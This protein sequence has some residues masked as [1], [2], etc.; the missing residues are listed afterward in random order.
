MCSAFLNYIS[1]ALELFDA[2]VGFD[3]LVS[4]GISVTFFSIC[5]VLVSLIHTMKIEIPTCGNLQN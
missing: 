1:L 3:L 5:T 2:M 4:L